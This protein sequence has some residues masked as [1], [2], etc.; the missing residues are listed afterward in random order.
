MLRRLVLC[1]VLLC[2]SVAAFAL[3]PQQALAIASGDSDERIAALN[4]AAASAA[5][6]LGPFV[7][8]LLDDS[9]KVAGDKAFIVQGDKAVDAATG[10][11]ATVPDDAEDVVNNNRVRGALQ[12][13]MGALQL[14]SPDIEARRAGV[15]ELLKQ[16]LEE[17]QLPLLEKAFAAETDAA[18][19]ASLERM[20]ATILV[21]SS[22][23]AKRLAA[24]TAL[25]GSGQGAVASLLQERLAPDAETDPEVRASLGRALDSVRDR[26]A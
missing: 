21:S 1:C 22:D 17:A 16:Q 23:K 7:Q 3:T 11:A 14:L 25:A 13:A 19:K 12:A 4:E 24:I 6:G 15:A 18:L 10:A 26:L 2:S 9:V 8:A 5:D 20:R